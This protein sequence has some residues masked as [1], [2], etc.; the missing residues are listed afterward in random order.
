MNMENIDAL[1][2]SSYNHIAHLLCYNHWNV[3]EQGK[4]NCKVYNQENHRIHFYIRHILVKHNLP[5]I[6][7][8][9]LRSRFHQLFLVYHMYNL[10]TMYK[11]INLQSDN[12][13]GSSLFALIITKVP[14]LQVVLLF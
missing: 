3:I 4:S 7:I 5:Y 1:N 8:D 13:T 9:L 14:I 11:K 12:L 6:D 2:H 10:N